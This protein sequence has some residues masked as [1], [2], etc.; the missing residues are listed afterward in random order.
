MDEG[1][2][3]HAEIDDLKGEAAFYKMIRWT[4]GEFAIEHGV[5]NKTRTIEADP[6][7]LLM[8]GLRLLDEEKDPEQVG[9]AATPY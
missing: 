1:T 3:S 7:Y 8:E 4:E 5:A 6:M 2:I 9:P